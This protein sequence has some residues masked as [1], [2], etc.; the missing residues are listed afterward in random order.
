MQQEVGTLVLKAV[1][2]GNVEEE[3]KAFLGKV[4][5]NVSDEKLANLI[6]KVP[7]VLSKNV[8]ANTGAKIVG[9]LERLGAKADFVSTTEVFATSQ[10]GLETQKVATC[11]T[12][13]L[14]GDQTDQTIEALKPEIGWGTRIKSLIIANLTEVNK[15][16]WLILS[17]LTLAGLM[18]Y[19]MTAQ[20][21]L[22]GLY[23]LPT[24][25]SAYF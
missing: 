5:R 17:L 18:N 15:E 13:S 25:F 21:M 2:S 11:K 6:G 3:V 22:L 19:I 20:R 16:L 12:E 1:P 9:N 10:Q 8:T 7:V 4:F 14:S 23:T 24:L